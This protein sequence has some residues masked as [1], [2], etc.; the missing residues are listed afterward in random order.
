MNRF[1]AALVCLVL[2]S[3]SGWPGAQT[4]GVVDDPDAGTKALLVAMGMV[5][6]G[7]GVYGHLCAPVQTPACNSPKTYADAKLIAQAMVADA[8]LVAAGK[9]S[10]TAATIIFALTQYQL[11]KTVA[12]SPGPTNPQAAPDQEARAYIDSIA[13]GDLLISTADSRVRAAYGVN[14]SVASLMAGLEAKVA[15]LP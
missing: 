9:R 8:Q 7:I 13:A 6:D 1:L 11:V 15:A 4:L 5:V 12:N 2:A 10:S 3:C 14:T